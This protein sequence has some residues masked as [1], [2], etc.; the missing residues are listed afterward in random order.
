MNTIASTLKA[1]LQRFRQH[2]PANAGSPGNI[3]VFRFVP[4]DTSSFAQAPD[5]P[6]GF[7]TDAWGENVFGASFKIYQDLRDRLRKSFIEG[8]TIVTNA[9]TGTDDNDEPTGYVIYMHE[10]KPV[11]GESASLIPEYHLA[12][13]QDRIYDSEYLLV[14]FVQWEMQRR[15]ASAGVLH[16]LTELPPCESCCGVLDGFLAANSA[17]HVKVYHLKSSGQAARR[18]APFVGAGRAA[19]HRI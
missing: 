14:N 8:C 17:V 4:D 10:I 9:V 19:L 18:L 15:G 12:A 1:S 13:S 7:G 2:I 16:L 6:G 5:A 11:E 3:G